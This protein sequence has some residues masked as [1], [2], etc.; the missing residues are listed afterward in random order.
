M[1]KTKNKKVMSKDIRKIHSVSGTMSVNTA[2][3]A[4]NAVNATVAEFD[5]VL[6]NASARDRFM[7]MLMERI[8]Q[9]EETRC[10]LERE[11]EELQS[12]FYYQDSCMKRQ[13]ARSIIADYRSHFCNASVHDPNYWMKMLINSLVGW[14]GNRPLM[15]INNNDILAYLRTITKNV[16]IYNETIACDLGRHIMSMTFEELEGFVLWDELPDLL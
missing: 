11:L 16:S 8:G 5:D 1:A 10:F 12:R 7:I 13:L 14:R 9:L 6:G 3:S 2:M 4:V 15:T